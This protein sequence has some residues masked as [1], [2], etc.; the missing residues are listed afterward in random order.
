M[1]FWKQFQHMTFQRWPFLSKM[2]MSCI[3]ME[4]TH[5]S[6]SITWFLLQ[7]H[8]LNLWDGSGSWFCKGLNPVQHGGQ[9]TVLK[10]EYKLNYK[11]KIG[12]EVN[13]SFTWKSKLQQITHLKKMTNARSISKSIKATYYKKHKLL[14]KVNFLTTF[15]GYILFVSQLCF[16]NFICWD[17]DSQYLRIKICLQEVIK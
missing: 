14:T 17:P 11:F 3:E 1:D 6:M 10:E 5:Y 2:Q 13:I 4:T 16:P 9:A 12:T 8:Q 15:Y 7:I